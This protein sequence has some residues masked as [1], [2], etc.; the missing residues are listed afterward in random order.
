MISF[1]KITRDPY[2]ILLHE[3]A[4]SGNLHP[5]I[6]D[7]LFK[8]ARALIIVDHIDAFVL[9]QRAE[10]VVPLHAVSPVGLRGLVAAMKIFAEA[11]AAPNRLQTAIYRRR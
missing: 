11:Q 4:R 6:E 9:C 5:A 7:I 10:T 8:G 2:R 3:T 1:S